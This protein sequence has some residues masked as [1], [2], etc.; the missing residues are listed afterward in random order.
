MLVSS[1]F[2]LTLGTGISLTLQVGSRERLSISAGLNHSFT[3]QG[4][5]P[6]NYSAFS[7]QLH[8]QQALT[9]LYN[10]SA[11]CLD[12]VECVTR[13]KGSVG[14]VQILTDIEEDYLFLAS[15]ECAG[16]CA[17]GNVTVLVA[18]VGVEINCKFVNC[19]T[20]PNLLLLLKGIIILTF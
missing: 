17:G 12:R 4:A 20:K 8:S 7:I 15:T 14:M 6:N 1:L 16:D 9:S 11:H 18:V 13:G 19:Q 5:T 2:I 3:V 10:G